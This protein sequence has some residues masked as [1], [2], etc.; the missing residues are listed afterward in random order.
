MIKQVHDTRT[1]IKIY[2][3]TSPI[4]NFASTPGRL[5]D[6]KYYSTAEDI[7]FEQKHGDNVLYIHIYIIFTYYYSMIQPPIL[8]QVGMK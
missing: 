3:I 2:N 8:E 4:N 7:Y 1:Q 6:L 5:I